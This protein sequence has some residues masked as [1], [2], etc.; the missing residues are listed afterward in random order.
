M[1][2]GE[3][4]SNQRELELAFITIS[5]QRAIKDPERQQLARTQ[6]IRNSLQ[7]KRHQLQSTNENFVD[8]TRSIVK[9]GKLR[10]TANNAGE[11]KQS[12]RSASLASSV[13][14]PF[15]T[16]T[17]D[18]NRLIILLQ[19]TREAGGPVFS[20]NSPIE[21]HGLRNMFNADLEDPGLS[22]AVCLALALAAKGGIMDREC[23]AYRLK[24]IQHVNRTLANPTEAAST[25]T[26]GTVLLL[27][28]VEVCRPNLALQGEIG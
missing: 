15:G 1:S 28:G 25:T 14:D 12:R 23:T 8:E 18:T 5:D 2:K 20:V 24:A 3:A 6:A 11:S 22:S 10:S 4:S 19:Q 27:V 9:R 13:V 21:F 7:R 17:L 26:I 16:I